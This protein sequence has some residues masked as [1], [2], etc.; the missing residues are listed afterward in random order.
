MLETVTL[1]EAQAHLADL[2]AG[3][4]PGA[5]LVITQDDRPVAKLVGPVSVP[6]QPRRPGSAKGKLIIHTEDDEHLA[7]FQEYL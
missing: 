7:D 6:R 2:I 3:L 4:D 1:Q 5:E